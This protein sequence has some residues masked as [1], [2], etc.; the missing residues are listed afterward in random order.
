MRAA[1]IS[2]EM[3][4]SRP[5]VVSIGL[6]RTAAIPSGISA[7]IR[8]R[9]H[10]VVGSS[11]CICLHSLIELV[12]NLGNTLTKVDLYS[13]IVNKRVVHFEV[14]LNSL[15]LFGKLNKGILKR[16]SSSTVSN[17]LCVDLFVE[18]RKDEF[19]ILI[20]RDW[21]EFADKQDSVGCFDFCRRQISQH[22]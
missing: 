8:I 22:F 15:F 14:C 5:V 11:S 10:P 9:R 3:M 4:H 13:S 21:I 12:P 7:A 2:G 20:L 16:I 17:D 19:Q 1:V 18:T 6:S